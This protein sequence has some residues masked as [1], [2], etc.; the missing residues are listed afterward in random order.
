MGL[1]SDLNH[2]D[3]GNKHYWTLVHPIDVELLF[4]S[5]IYFSG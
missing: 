5:V 1:L 4:F 2:I 3:F